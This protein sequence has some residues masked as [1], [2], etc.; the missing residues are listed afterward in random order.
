M[1]PDPRLIDGL[2][3]RVTAVHKGVDSP[4]V[5]LLVARR[6]LHQ[7]HDLL[8]QP[9]YLVN[10]LRTSYNSRNTQVVAT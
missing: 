4:N 10:N 7:K 2:A 8:R 6:C 1:I 9:F 3:W 5:R